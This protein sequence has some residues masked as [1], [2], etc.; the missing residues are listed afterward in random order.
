MVG[1]VS[2][3][4]TLPYFAVIFS[5]VKRESIEGYAEM[6]DRM[7]DLAHQ[8]PGFL[9]VDSASAEVGITVSYWESMESIKSWKQQAEHK[10]AQE[11]GRANW[12]QCYTIRIARVEREYEFNFE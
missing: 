9:G 2:D 4:S 7:W 12:Y 1:I 11:R 10:I 3:L 6:A 5:S 8:Q